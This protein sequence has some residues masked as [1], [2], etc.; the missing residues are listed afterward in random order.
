[1]FILPTQ[2]AVAESDQL[3]GKAAQSIPVMLGQAM[4]AATKLL[5]AASTGYA[6]SQHVGFCANML[7]CKHVPLLK[8]HC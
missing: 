1:M 8:L 5:A 4:P 2:A 6:I 3:S 7:G